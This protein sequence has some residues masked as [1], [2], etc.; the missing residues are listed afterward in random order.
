[1]AVEKTCKNTEQALGGNPTM[2][3]SGNGV[4]IYQPVE[5]IVLEQESQFA[6]FEQPSQTFLNP[7]YKLLVYLVLL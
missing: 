3:W 1:M 7:A 6:E 5:A 4:H 2:L